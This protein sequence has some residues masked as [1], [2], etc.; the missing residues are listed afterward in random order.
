[1]ILSCENF[2]A[3][4]ARGRD[5]LLARLFDRLS[6]FES[7]QPIAFVRRPDRGPEALYREVACNGQRLGAR[8]AQEFM[9]DYGAALTDLPAL[10]APFETFAGR[11]VA[12]GDYDA[13]ATQGRLWSAFSALAGLGELALAAPAAP[14]Y[15]TPTSAEVQAARLANA[16]IGSEA[17]RRRVLRGFFASEGETGGPDAPLLSPQDRLALVDGFAERSAV[18]AQARGYAPDLADLRAA[19]ATETWRPPAGPDGAMLERLQQA[20]LQAE[21]EPHPPQPSVRPALAGT[22]E[23]TIRIRPRPWLTRAIGRLRDLRP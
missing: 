23:M 4:L 1:V 17:Q 15:R 3:P 2:L 10:F 13:A 7:C 22:P 14:T 21:F 5:D 19:L 8:S 6:A 20:R 12:L 18:F 11:P 9:V 16:L